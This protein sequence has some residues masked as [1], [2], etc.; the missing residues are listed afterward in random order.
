[1]C[2]LGSTPTPTISLSLSL[3]ISLAAVRWADRFRI[4]TR[5]SSGHRTTVCISIYHRTPSRSPGPRWRRRRRHRLLTN[6][7]E[8]RT[9]VSVSDKRASDMGNYCCLHGIVGG[10]GRQP[11]GGRWTGR[12]CLD[13]DDKTDTRRAS[14]F[15]AC[16]FSAR[17]WIRLMCALCVRFVCFGTN[18]HAHCVG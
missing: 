14:T 13:D 2:V 15:R 18:K 7:H 12:R 17:T 11:I 3:S 9:K 4:C 16:A 8:I 5:P 1:M 10:S 6:T